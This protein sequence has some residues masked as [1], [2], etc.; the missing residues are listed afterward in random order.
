MLGTKKHFLRDAAPRVFGA[1][2][3]LCLPQS[4]DQPLPWPAIAHFN[5]RIIPNRGK[6]GLG[7]KP[8]PEVIVAYYDT[9]VN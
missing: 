5:E 7:I 3:F 2:R 1:R 6:D 4:R 9:M 8:K